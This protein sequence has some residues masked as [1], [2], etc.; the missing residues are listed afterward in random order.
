MRVREL[1][2]VFEMLGDMGITVELDYKIRQERQF[3][4]TSPNTVR[5]KVKIRKGNILKPEKIEEI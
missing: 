5:Y 1:D 4:I 3:I 2:W